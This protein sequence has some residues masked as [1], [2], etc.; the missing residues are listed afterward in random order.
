[1]LSTLLPFLKRSWVVHRP[2]CRSWLY[3]SFLLLQVHEVG[4]FLQGSPDHP[5]LGSGGFALHHCGF[6]QGLRPPL[7]IYHLWVTGSWTPAPLPCN[8]VLAAW[9]TYFDLSKG[10]EYVWLLYMTFSMNILAKKQKKHT[11]KKQQKPLPSHPT[12]SKS[13][14]PAEAEVAQAHVALLREEDVLRPRSVETLRR[15]VFCWGE[16]WGWVEAVRYEV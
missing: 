2:S 14:W 5:W 4:V 1:M 3:L 11:K 9:P 7:G 10:C 13:R 6:Y 15:S 8:G 16:K 12:R